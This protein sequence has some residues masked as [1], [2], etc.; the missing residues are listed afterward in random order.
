METFELAANGR[1]HHFDTGPFNW[2]IISQAGRLTLVDAGLPGHYPVFLNGLRS[3]GCGLKDVEA[4][5]LTHAH[6]DHTG[7][8]EALRRAA[9]VPVFIHRDDLALSRRVLN[10]PWDGLLTN[11]WRPYVVSIFGRAALNGVFSMPRLAQAYAFKD[12]DTLDVPG[13][14]RVIHVPGHTPG[15]AVFHLPEAGMLLSGDALITRDLLTGTQGP[16]QVPASVLNGNDEEARRSLDRLSGLGMVT[17]L[18]GHGKPWKG[19][20]AA[21]IGGKV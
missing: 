6:A 12:G 19:D 11:A 21:A 15:E 14:P 7:F 1:L 16:P 18:P 10:L 2:Y 20:L 5:I 13:T 9:N 3:L 8:A 17:V 4:V